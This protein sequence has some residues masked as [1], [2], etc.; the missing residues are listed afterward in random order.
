MTIAN[1]PDVNSG[2][3]KRMAILL[4]GV[5]LS[6]P[7]LNSPIRGEGQI[8]GNFSKKDVEFLVQILNSGS[9][10]GAISKQPISENIVGATMGADAI[11]KGKWA[12][13][14]GLLTTV[15]CVV[16]YYRFSGVIATIALC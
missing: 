5:V 2:F 12:S 9:L 7:S 16:A 11:A 1:Q 3:K 8:E 13:W 4:D 10:P 15:L 6:A 14:L